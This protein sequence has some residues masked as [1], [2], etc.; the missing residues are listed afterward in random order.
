MSAVA[1]SAR[2]WPPVCAAATLLAV[3]TGS[4]SALGLFLGPIAETTSLGAASVSLAIAAGLLAF[5]AAQPAWGLCERR[6]GAPRIIVL[7]AIGTGASLALLAVGGGALLLATAAIAGG[8]TAAA[9]GAPLLMGIVAQR[10]PAHR[11]ALAMGLISAGGSAGQLAYSLVGAALIAAAGWQPAL[12]AFAATLL[13]AAPLARAF[14]DAPSAPAAP[15]GRRA[16]VPAALG[17]PS[18]WYV[19]AGFFVCGF[20]VSFLTTHMPGVVDLCGLPPTFS[21][22]WL[23]IVGA[24]NIAGSLAAGALMQRVP[25]R[26]LLGL[27]YA[28]RAL[29]V[30][31]FIALP[32]G[33][34]VLLGFALWMGLTY[35]ATLPLTTGLLTRLYGARSLAVLFGITMATHQVGSFLGAWLGGVEFELTGGYHWIWIADILLAV[36]AALLHLPVREAAAVIPR[37]PDA[38]ADP[39]PAR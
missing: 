26:T 24:C 6:I 4:R 36:V 14:S 5:G 21:G 30:A 19:T 7:G 29:G 28:L 25:M 35:M 8:A 22:V 23:A 12:L 3:A 10:L 31:A 37:L 32:P 15:E 9:L 16:A 2:F 38:V 17:D 18:Y 20:H 39:L 34:T 27:V 11:H 33:R 13:A 1:G